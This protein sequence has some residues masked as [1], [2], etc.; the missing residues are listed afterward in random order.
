MAKRPDT[1]LPSL[2]KTCLVMDPARSATTERL[3]IY[4]YCDAV[5]MWRPLRRLRDQAGFF[6]T[7]QRHALS[8]FSRPGDIA[9]WSD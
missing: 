6:V 1:Q 8:A 2:N 5:S 4:C 9:D 7:E 3:Q